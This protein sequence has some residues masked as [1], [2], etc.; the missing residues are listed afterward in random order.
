M[1]TEAR[2]GRQEM[3]QKAIKAADRCLKGKGYIA[4]VDVLMEMGRL[5]RENHAR[6][7]ARQ[8]PFLERVLV[9]NL[10]Q[11]QVII[12]AV[13]KNS[14]HGGLKPSRTVYTSWGKGPRQ[15][16][17][18]SKTGNPAIEAAYSTHFVGKGASAPAP[19]PTLGAAAAQESPSKEPDVSSGAMPGD[20]PTPPNKRTKFSDTRSRSSRSGRPSADA[21][22]A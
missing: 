16:L 17:R 4:L 18:F 20:P 21:S 10:A 6:W 3:A 1:K 22:P 9:G 11:L 14:M 8:V 15:R 5:T 19:V 2:M 13:A 12:R 7:R